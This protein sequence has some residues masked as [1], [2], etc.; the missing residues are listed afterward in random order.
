[1]AAVC[2]ESGKIICPSDA[3]CA[4]GVNG[5]ALMPRGRQ[6]GTE[7]V[8]AAMIVTPQQRQVVD[9]CHIQEPT[10]YGPK[11]PNPDKLA[12]SG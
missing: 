8:D 10:R 4:L 6:M 5:G 9:P 7:L 11:S 12:K 1:M 2:R 3:A